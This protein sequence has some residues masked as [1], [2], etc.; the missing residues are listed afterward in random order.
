MFEDT[1]LAPTQASWKER[2]PGE[3]YGSVEG[4]IGTTGERE[5]LHA[6]LGDQ[7]AAQLQRQQP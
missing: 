2:G 7:G 1:A 3:V 4:L 6:R 5:E